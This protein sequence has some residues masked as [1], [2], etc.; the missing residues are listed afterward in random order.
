MTQVKGCE[1]RRA[2]SLRTVRSRR[3]A[4]L[5]QISLLLLLTA[6]PIP[7]EALITVGA[8]EFPGKAQ[9]VEIVDQFAY[10]AAR[11]AGL[12]IID[13]SNPSAPLEVAIVDTP[14]TALGVEV[15]GGFACRRFKNGK[16]GDRL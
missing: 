2:V 10:V 5:W 7:A 8:V 16:T 3:S 13:I 11:S 15:V 14:G 12:R 6:A 1:S 9:D 4:F